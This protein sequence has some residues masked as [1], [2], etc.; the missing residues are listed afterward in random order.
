MKYL[1]RATWDDYN[2]V[3]RMTMDFANAHYQELE[4]EEWKVAETVS[5]YLE[6]DGTSAIIVLIMD[7]ELNTPIGLIAGTL[8][9][10]SFSEGSVAQE[11]MWWMDPAHRNSSCSVKLVDAFELWAEK[12]KAKYCQLCSVESEHVD[13]VNKFYL[14]KK[15]K[16]IENSFIKR[17]N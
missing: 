17:L 16:H 4:V 5:G 2:D 10:L 9:P 7:D 1:K 3:L 14:R 12:V 8:T 15:Y 11:T 6:N 13:K